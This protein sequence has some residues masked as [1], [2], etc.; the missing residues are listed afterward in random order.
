[1]LFC[2]IAG[3]ERL[4][5]SVRSFPE[6]EEYPYCLFRKL[7]IVD[8]SLEF[9][10][11]NFRSLFNAVEKHMICF[12][13]LPFSIFVRIKAVKREYNLN[14]GGVIAKGDGGKKLTRYRC[15]TSGPFGVLQVN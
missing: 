14:N 2:D 8:S 3:D 6:L 11:R 12:V 4:I 9:M 10:H 13:I 1:M 15:A 7:G 5:A